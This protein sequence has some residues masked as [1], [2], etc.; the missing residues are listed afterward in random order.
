MCDLPTH[1]WSLIAVQLSHCD[2]PRTIIDCSR[3]VCSLQKV[4]TKLRNCGTEAFSALTLT[5]PPRGDLDNNRRL[6][7]WLPL[8]VTPTL[9]QGVREIKTKKARQA[10]LEAQA[11]ARQQQDDRRS[12]IVAELANKGLALR[13]DSKLCERYIMYGIGEPDKIAIVMDEMDWLFDNTGYASILSEVR[14]S[15]TD[16]FHLFVLLLII[17]LKVLFAACPPWCYVVASLCTQS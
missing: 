7:S 8:A 12:V 9:W 6:Y 10:Q 1:L 2:E 5:C 16:C 14:P 11:L 15:R 4:S 3:D 13:S 17:S